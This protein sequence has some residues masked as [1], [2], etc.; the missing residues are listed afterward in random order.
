[1]LITV[2]LIIMA[3]SLIMMVGCILMAVQGAKEHVAWCIG[4]LFMPMVGII[5]TALHWKKYKWAR[6]GLFVYIGGIIAMIGACISFFAASPG[7]TA[8]L[9]ELQ[10]AQEDLNRE[11]VSLLLRRSSGE[12]DLS[13][14]LD[15]LRQKQAELEAQ[16]TAVIIEMFFGPDAPIL[17]EL[18]ISSSTEDPTAER[19]ESLPPGDPFD[20]AMKLAADAEAQ[21]QSAET[22]E[23]WREV[24]NTWAL[25]VTLL[26]LVPDAN[27]NYASAQTKIMIFNQN[28]AYADSNSR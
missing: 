26:E 22:K 1:M 14:E 8:E 17:D 10:E 25:S 15:R 28:K 21:M 27:P 19:L 6:R 13:E 7:L 23:D 20:G 18:T 9:F 3:A 2:S 12:E 16:Q 24:A 5:F 11:Q 4:A